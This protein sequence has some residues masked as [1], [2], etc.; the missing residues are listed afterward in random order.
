MSGAICILQHA[1]CADMRLL[2]PSSRTLMP[3]ACQALYTPLSREHP[4]TRRMKDWKMP[5]ACVVVGCLFSP[6]SEY[7]VG[8][9]NFQATLAGRSQSAIRERNSDDFTFE[10]SYEGK[11]CEVPI[12][13]DESILSA[14]ERAGVSDELL[15]PDL[16]SDC[17]RGNCMTCS[18]K[19]LDGSSKS[20]LVKGDDGLSPHVSQ[21]LERRGY[22]LLCSS[23]VVGDGLKLKIGE[24]HE[25]WDDMFRRRL[26]DDSA[27][28]IGRAA[29]AKTIRLNSEQDVE[30]WAEEAEKLFKNSG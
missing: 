7:A 23:G 15:I 17:R 14:M 4:T 27:Q 22:I 1:P 29:M 12:R 10:V 8:W 30:R 24:K 25:A 3:F 19:H 20:S 2:A 13:Q 26:E 9:I 11:T 21:E 28:H 5:I 18:G 16:P 6:F